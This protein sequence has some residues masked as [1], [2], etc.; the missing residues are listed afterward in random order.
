MDQTLS[1][2]SHSHGKSLIANPEYQIQLHK[3]RSLPPIKSSKLRIQ[4]LQTTYHRLTC[5]LP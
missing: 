4:N 2:K 3:L 5:H 1:E